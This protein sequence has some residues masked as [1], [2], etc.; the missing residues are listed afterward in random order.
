MI[1]HLQDAM[2]LAEGVV[3]PI[4]NSVET[5]YGVNPYA[6]IVVSFNSFSGHFRIDP[7]IPLNTQITYIANV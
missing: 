1:T 5:R 4:I 6:P 7:V 3:D 2:Q